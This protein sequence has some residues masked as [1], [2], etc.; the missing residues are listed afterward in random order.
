MLQL[1][2]VMTD[3]GFKISLNVNAIESV[4]PLVA[5]EGR[6]DEM[7]ERLPGCNSVINTSKGQIIVKETYAE[8]LVALQQVVH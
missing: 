7:A 1:I 3:Q 6:E 8:I 5:A 2:E 4:A